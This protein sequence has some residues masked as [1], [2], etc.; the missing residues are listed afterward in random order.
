MQETDATQAIFGRFGN[1]G[2]QEFFDAVI[3]PLCVTYG[4]E[5]DRETMS[6]WYNVL[7]EFRCDTLREA[8]AR[9]AAKRKSMPTPANIAES[10]RAVEAEKAAGPDGSLSSGRVL[11]VCRDGHAIRLW[12]GVEA[13]CRKAGREA[14]WRLWLAPCAPHKLEG[15]TLHIFVPTRLIR[16]RLSGQ[17]TEARM[18]EK[19]LPMGVRTRAEVFKND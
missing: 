9:A 1:I 8:V 16:D 3:R 6:L 17:T 5:F 2:K 19:G 10:C 13:Y 7:K 15:T 18:L 11:Y 4:K 12:K 14:A